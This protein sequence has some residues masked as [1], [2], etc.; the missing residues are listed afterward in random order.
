[1][2]SN[3][4]S[5]AVYTYSLDSNSSLDNKINIQLSEINFP[6]GNVYLFARLPKVPVYTSVFEVSSQS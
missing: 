5:L 2:K 3:K 6:S 1:M 4:M